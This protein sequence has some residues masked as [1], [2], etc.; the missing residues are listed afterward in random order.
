MSRLTIERN[1]GKDE[2]DAWDVRWRTTSTSKCSGCSVFWGRPSH[3]RQVW[4]ACTLVAMFVPAPWTKS[5]V[6]SVW[7]T[8]YSIALVIIG[9]FQPPNCWLYCIGFTG[10]NALFAEFND[11]WVD[12]GVYKVWANRWGLCP[13]TCRH[14]V[15]DLRSK[16]NKS[17]P[18]VQP[19]HGW[20]SRQ[21]RTSRIEIYHHPP[22]V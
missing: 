11:G 5:P 9:W 17:F 19:K 14:V 22:W 2:T 13:R 3:F 6:W 1:L 20:H 10:N 8:G 15:N 21:S 12:S 18:D 7:V 16:T 4:S